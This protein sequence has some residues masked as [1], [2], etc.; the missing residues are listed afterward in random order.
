MKC[1]N[2]RVRWIVALMRVFV[3]TRGFNKKTCK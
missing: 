1:S 3:F 2:L